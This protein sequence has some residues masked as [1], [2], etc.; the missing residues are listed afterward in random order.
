MFL[1]GNCVNSQNVE[2]GKVN[3]VLTLFLALVQQVIAA[4]VDQSVNG[5]FAF[6]SV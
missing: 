3:R 5:L 1:E 4:C 6:W 2:G